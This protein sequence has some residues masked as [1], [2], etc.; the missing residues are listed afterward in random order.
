MCPCLHELVSRNW[1]I[2]SVY[3]DDQLVNDTVDQGSEPDVISGI[4]K[5]RGCLSI[6]WE[7]VQGSLL[8]E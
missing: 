4:P 7:H 5:R 8:I 3:P 6:R 1:L 2:V